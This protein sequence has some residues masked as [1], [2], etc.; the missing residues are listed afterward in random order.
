MDNPF[1]LQVRS[2]VTSVTWVGD[3][4]DLTYVKTDERNNHTIPC[5][6]VVVANGQY[7]LPVVPMFPGLDTFQGNQGLPEGFNPSIVS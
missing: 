1:V 6:Y 4:W 7:V 2:L 5:D 3:H